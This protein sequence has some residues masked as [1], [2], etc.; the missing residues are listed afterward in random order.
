MPTAW[1]MLLRKS[2]W[3]GDERTFFLTLF[4]GVDAMMLHKFGTSFEEF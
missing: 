2:V 4:V 3:L 1:M